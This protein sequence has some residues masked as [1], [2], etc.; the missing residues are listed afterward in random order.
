MDSPS[1]TAADARAS[2]PALETGKAGPANGKGASNGKG[3]GEPLLPSDSPL[4][5]DLNVTLQARL[6]EAIMPI[7]ELL[8]LREGSVLSLETRMNEPVELYLNGALVGR[9][10]IVAV[11]DRFGVRIVEIA[12]A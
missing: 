6:G 5:K 12:A 8:A 3:A 9:G 10:E 1:T 2:G 7:A 4:L 11:D